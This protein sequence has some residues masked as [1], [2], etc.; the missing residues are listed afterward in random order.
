[1]KASFLS[2]LRRL[3]GTAEL[4]PNAGDNEWKLLND[5]RDQFTHLLQGLQRPE[6]CLLPLR[7]DL[8]GSSRASYRRSNQCGLRFR[9]L[10]PLD[11]RCSGTLRMPNGRR[12]L[13]T[14]TATSNISNKTRL[15][16]KFTTVGPKLD[17]D[18]TSSR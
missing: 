2:L 5:G 4:V 15:V 8:L 3:N 6:F 13:R 16:I 11:M 10:A 7:I 9:V 14:P 1:M 18:G 17:F 12:F